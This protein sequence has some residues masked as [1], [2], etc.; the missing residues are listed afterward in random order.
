MFLSGL[1][2]N[3]TIFVAVAT[4][5][6]LK[7][8]IASARKVESDDYYSQHTSADSLLTQPRVGTDF[9]KIKKKID[10]M[11]LN[12]IAI[13]KKINNNNHYRSG[14]ERLLAER[15]GGD[16]FDKFEYEDENEVG[17]LEDQWFAEEE[18]PVL[19]LT[20]IEE[21]PTED[22]QDKKEIMIEENLIKLIIG[23]ELTLQQ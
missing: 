15:R 13:T 22:E 10:K 17:E 16:T 23:K 4:P 8:A 2:N 12:Y 1:K 9:E 6:N 11:V 19:Y 21:V 7:E 14:K 20:T 5:K 3:N 18:N